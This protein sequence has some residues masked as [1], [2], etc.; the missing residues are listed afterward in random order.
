MLKRAIAAVLLRISHAQLFCVQAGSVRHQITGSNLGSWF[1]RCAVYVQVHATAGKLGSLDPD[2]IRLG[3][4]ATFSIYSLRNSY[5]LYR[6]TNNH[7]I[8]QLEQKL[9]HV[10]R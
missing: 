1:F 10:C 5:I 8:E 6:K 7:N 2:W 3:N 9:S 4:L